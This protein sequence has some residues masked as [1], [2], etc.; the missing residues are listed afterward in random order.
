MAERNTSRTRR[1][2]KEYGLGLGVGGVSAVYG[3]YA[4][5]S[6]H[7]WLPGLRGGNSAVTG[8]HGVAVAVAYLAGGLYLLCRH[9]LDPRAK[10]DLGRGEAY[11]AETALLVVL[12]GCLVYVLLR[13]GTAG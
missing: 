8:A 9:F 13:V 1:K 6:Q 5:M 3:V 4:L 2:L 12:I 7:A 11:L 10:T